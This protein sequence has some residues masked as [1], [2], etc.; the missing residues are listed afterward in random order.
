[1]SYLGWPLN[2]QVQRAGS[3]IRANCPDSEPVHLNINGL[4]DSGRAVGA[5]G[6][7]IEYDINKET[8]TSTIAIFVDDERVHP[9][10][11]VLVYEGMVAPQVGIGI[12]VA[13]GWRIGTARGHLDI[14]LYPCTREL[15]LHRKP[16]TPEEGYISDRGRIV[17]RG[18]PPKQEPWQNFIGDPID[19]LNVITPAM[20]VAA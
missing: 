20:P 12:G 1:M 9:H 11:Y 5:I 19:V 13:N 7:C 17:W 10:G 8:A 4:T 18:S 6:T 3:G 16:R 15:E 14:N 2:H